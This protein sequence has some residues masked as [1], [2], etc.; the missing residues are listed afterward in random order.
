MA[1]QIGVPG[2]KLRVLS[3]WRGSSVEVYGSIVA[4]NGL[5]GQDEK[6][7]DAR[8]LF[9]I[10]IQYL[11]IFMESPKVQILLSLSTLQGPCPCTFP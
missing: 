3:I 2:A 8:K 4:Y 7:T 5:E 11:T 1:L 6:G 10:V 9:S